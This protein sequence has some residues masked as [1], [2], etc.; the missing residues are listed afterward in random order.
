MARFVLALDQGTTSSRAILFDGRGRPVA[1]ALAGL[2]VG[3]W[4]SMG[5]ISGIAGWDRASGTARHWANPGA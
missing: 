2:A 4:K 3:V 1:A 5:Q